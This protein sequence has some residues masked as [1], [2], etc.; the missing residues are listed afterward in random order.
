M[1][2]EVIRTI[3]RCLQFNQDE[4]PRALDNTHQIFLHDIATDMRNAGAEGKGESRL[5]EKVATVRNMKAEGFDTAVISRIT[6]L[7]AAEIERLG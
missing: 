7:S 6:G 1:K 5:E 4:Q 3:K 2:P